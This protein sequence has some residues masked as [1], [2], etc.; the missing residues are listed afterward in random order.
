MVGGASTKSENMYKTKEN[1]PTT[2]G[3][4]IRELIQ[5]ITWKYKRF[6]RRILKP[7]LI[8]LSFWKV[9]NAFDDLKIATELAVAHIHEQDECLEN[10]S[11]NVEV[12]LKEIIRIKM[13]YVGLSERDATREAHA[14]FYGYDFIAEGGY[15]E[16]IATEGYQQFLYNVNSDF[17]TE[18][19]NEDA[20][21]IALDNHVT[22]DPIGD[23]SL[24]EHAKHYLLQLKERGFYEKEIFRK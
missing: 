11:N 1:R 18:Q 4:K 17:L 5:P 9:P 21:D 22:S 14:R 12:L 13:K 24:F 6:D 10:S 20:F 2:L 19:E 8:M 15:S 23:A 16:R 3:Q 7:W